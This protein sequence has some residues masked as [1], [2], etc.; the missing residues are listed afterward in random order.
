MV[1]FRTFDKV[2]YAL[3]MDSIRPT[4]VGYEVKHPGRALL[5]PRRRSQ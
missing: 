2:S 3:V 5:S 4:R 1:V